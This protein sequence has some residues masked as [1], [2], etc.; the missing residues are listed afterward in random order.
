M[1]IQ[2]IIQKLSFQISSSQEGFEI[3][4]HSNNLEE[5]VKNFAH[6]IRGNLLVTN[7]KVYHS[8]GTDGWRNLCD[9]Q[10]DSGGLL[11]SKSP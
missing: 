10:D 3:L 5:L 6:I 11:K 7:M 9:K 1:D 4:S 2:S 8:H